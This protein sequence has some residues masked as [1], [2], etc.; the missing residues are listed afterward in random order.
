LRNACPKPRQ[1]W[2]DDFERSDFFTKP[3]T[4]TDKAKV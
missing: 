3:F 2:E 4:K 1:I